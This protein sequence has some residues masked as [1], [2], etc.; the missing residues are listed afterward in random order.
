MIIKQKSKAKEIR[1]RFA[2][3]E[4]KGL[5]VSLHST[6]H[7]LV[8]HLEMQADLRMTAEGCRKE[9]VDTIKMFYVTKVRNNLPIYGVRQKSLGMYTTQESDVVKGISRLP[10]SL[11]RLD[12]EDLVDIEALALRQS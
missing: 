11:A 2:Y 7:E 4:L 12:D 3:G 5:T 6:S 10:L 8:C 9:I 1:L